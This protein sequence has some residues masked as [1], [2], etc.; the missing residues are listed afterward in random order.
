[1]LKRNTVTFGMVEIKVT[2]KQPLSDDV[3][4]S[5]LLVLVF[6]SFGKVKSP[7]FLNLCCFS[8]IR[9]ILICLPMELKP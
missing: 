4:F 9:V 2:N 8:H 3:F 1:M 5:P 7:F 6:Y